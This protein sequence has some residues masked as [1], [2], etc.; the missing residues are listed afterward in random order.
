MKFSYLKAIAYLNAFLLCLGCLYSDVMSKE[1][2]ENLISQNLKL[3]STNK[4]IITFF[5]NQDWVY[6]FNRHLNRYR[7]RDPEE[8]TLPE[9]LGRHRIYIYVD[10]E[11]K[12]I[13]AEV[14]KLFNFI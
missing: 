12:F 5:K 2:I 4:E 13:R 6:G 8:D 9:Y 10:D 7:A 11:K 3:G 1:E 14:E